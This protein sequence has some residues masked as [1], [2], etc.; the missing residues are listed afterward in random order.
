MKSVLELV[1][2]RLYLHN[3]VISKKGTQGRISAQKDDDYVMLRT[4]IAI[5]ELPGVFVTPDGRCM[6]QSVPG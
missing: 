6:G 4:A 3:T 5:H 2:S 1:L